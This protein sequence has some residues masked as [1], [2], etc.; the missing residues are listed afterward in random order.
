MFSRYEL[1]I[2]SWRRRAIWPSPRIAAC[3]AR[4]CLSYAHDGPNDSNLPG[5]RATRLVLTGVPGTRLRQTGDSL[6]V[7]NTYKLLK[8][9]DKERAVRSMANTTED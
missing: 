3:M 6:Q 8:L 7:P 2:V 1:A 5:E 9:K 4:T